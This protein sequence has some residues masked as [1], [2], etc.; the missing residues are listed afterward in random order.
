MRKVVPVLIQEPL[1][2]ALA[3]IAAARA[4]NEAAE[5]LVPT[6]L[7]DEAELA[8]RLCETH[9]QAQIG[10]ALG[11]GR[12]QRAH[13]VQLKKN[14]EKTWKTIVTT[15]EIQSGKKKTK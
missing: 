15:F 11:W 12:E 14:E 3:E 1:S 10:K 2:D 9:T 8:W 5:S 6:T 7:I 13:H 4:A